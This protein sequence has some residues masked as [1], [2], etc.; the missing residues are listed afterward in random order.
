MIN[1]YSESSLH[2]ALKTAYAIQ[3][4]GKTEVNV[5]NKVCDIVTDTGD[6]IEI[7]TQQLHAL[8]QKI[9]ALI[10][11]HRITVVRPLVCEKYIETYCGNTLLTR[12]KSPKK[13]TLYTICR[14]LSSIYQFLDHPHF[15]LELP[16][17]AVCEIREQT[18]APTQLPNKSRRFLRCWQKTDKKLERLYEQTYLFKTKYD[19]LQL[20]PDSLPQE[21]STAELPQAGK[22]ANWCLWLLHKAALISKTKTVHR[23]I[24]YIRSTNRQERI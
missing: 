9:A 16:C 13:E 6:I 2:R 15:I 3:Y 17:V 14:E 1:T 20:L 24:Y 23:R 5:Q 7:Q 18:D 8:R 22:Y 10:D 19:L 4:S 21:F 11:E 12:R